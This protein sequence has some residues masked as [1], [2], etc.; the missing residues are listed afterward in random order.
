[1]ET[2]SEAGD[3]EVRVSEDKKC[4]VQSSQ[5]AGWNP[6]GLIS[7]ARSSSDHENNGRRYPV[8]KRAA[9]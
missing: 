7:K 6:E 9:E 8:I 4:Q 1:M 3:E 2:P 5:L